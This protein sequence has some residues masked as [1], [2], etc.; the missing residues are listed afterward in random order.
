MEREENLAAFYHRELTAYNI[1]WNVECPAHVHYCMEI[2]L[3]TQGTL[4]VTIN[5]QEYAVSQGEGVF[6]LPFEVHS[7]HSCQP[8]C[9]RIVE[10]VINSVPVFL[11][12]VRKTQPVDRLFPVPQE[13]LVLLDRN[14]PLGSS[15][16]DD[17]HIQAAVVPLCGVIC[18]HCAFRDSSVYL[19]DVF[20][21]ALDYLNR[22]FA[23]DI[24][25]ESVA[26]AVGVHPVTLSRLFARNARVGFNTYLNHLRTV[27]AAHLL[28]DPLVTSTDAAYRSGFGSLRSFNRVFAKFTGLTP[29]AFRCL[30]QREKNERLTLNVL[31]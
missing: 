5:E 22:C 27:N 26:D 12:R 13:C 19:E 17:M 15:Q 29:S 7:F 6:V 21:A 4:Q 14:L 23:Q 9:C 16:Q 18:D 25:L 24:T 10:F 28:E 30:S 1:H 20:L 11:D 3:V 8:N 31:P 2:I